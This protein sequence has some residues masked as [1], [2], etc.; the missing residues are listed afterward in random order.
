MD[1]PPLTRAWAR[2]ALAPGAPAAGAATAAVL[3]ELDALL[4][5]AAGLH[6]GKRQAEALA[7]RAL[8]LDAGGDQ[9][10]AL[11][12]LA[13]ALELARPGGLRRT[14]LDLG[15]PLARLLRVLAVRGP[16]TAYLRQLLT[17]SATSSPPPAAGTGPQP[18]GPQPAGPL[19]ERELEVL[20]CLARRLSNKEIAAELHVTPETVKTHAA[21][22]Y[23]K[24]GA[25]GRWAAAQRAAELG[26]LP[27]AG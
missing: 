10:A 25:G 3:A 9:P 20:A 13:A 11:E 18:A 19:T 1:S 12:S 8:A 21:H 24:L 15:A 17:D 2:L 26:L 27:T 4:D 16:R 14:F 5:S 7:L 6:L 22:L 23:A